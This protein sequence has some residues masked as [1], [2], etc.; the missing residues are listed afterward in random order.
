MENARRINAVLLP[1]NSYRD[2]EAL[3]REQGKSKTE[4][5]R[6]AVALER[7]FQEARQE[8]WR[9]LVERDGEVREIISR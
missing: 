8:G 3:A 9:I 7:W 1:E 6:D 4:V 2:L 5:L